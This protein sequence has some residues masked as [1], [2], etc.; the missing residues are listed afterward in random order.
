MIEIRELKAKVV[1]VREDMDMNAR[2]AERSEN[3]LG[4]M[5]QIITEKKEESKKHK[6]LLENLRQD[7]SDLQ[8]KNGKLKREL[9]E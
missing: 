6:L 9:S 4:I 8:S 5:N 7:R 3:Q 1:K 2:R